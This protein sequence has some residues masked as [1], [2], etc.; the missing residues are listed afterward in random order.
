M[1]LPCFSLLTWTSY[2]CSRMAKLVLWLQRQ[3]VESWCR[4]STTQPVV[5]QEPPASELRVGMEQRGS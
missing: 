2:T 4:V 1:W 5:A 3:V